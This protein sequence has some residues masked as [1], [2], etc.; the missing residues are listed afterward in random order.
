MVATAGALVTVRSVDDGVGVAVVAG[1]IGLMSFFS[2]KWVSG[3]DTLFNAS[4]FLHLGLALS[5][6]PFGALAGAVTESLAMTLRHKTGLF[7]TVFNVSNIFLS[8]LGAWAAYHAVTALP[9]HG[10]VVSGLAGATAGFTHWAVNYLLLSGVVA[11]ATGRP[12]WNQMR[13]SVSIV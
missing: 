4:A 5:V 1:A 2:V 9:A 12:F 13:E 7:R 8:N 11:V 3:V 10:P 6:G